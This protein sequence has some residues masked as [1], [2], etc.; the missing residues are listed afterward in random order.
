MDNKR[1]HIFEQNFRILEREFQ[2]PPLPFRKQGTQVKEGVSGFENEYQKYSF[3]LVVLKELKFAIQMKPSIRDCYSKKA[4]YFERKLNRF[5]SEHGEEFHQYLFDIQLEKDLATYE[6]ETD[7][8]LTERVWN[9]YVNDN[10]KID[11]YNLYIVRASIQ[12]MIEELEDKFDLSYYKN[13]LKK[14]DDLLLTRI[15]DSEWSEL[16]EIVIWENRFRSKIMPKEYWWWHL[17]EVK[18]GKIKPNL[19]Y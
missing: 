11:L 7:W 12:Y 2:S 13:R 9:N 6:H 3:V 18:E 19:G 15:K 1:P 8:N 10:G 14:S 16:F 4:K 5:I 17:K